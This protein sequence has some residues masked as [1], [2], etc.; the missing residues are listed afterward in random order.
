MLNI[1]LD[2]ELGATFVYIW[3]RPLLKMNLHLDPPLYGTVRMCQDLPVYVCLVTSLKAVIHPASPHSTIFRL[4]SHTLLYNTEREVNY[5]D[6]GNW[7]N[8]IHLIMYCL[9]LCKK[10]YY[11]FFFIFINIVVLTNV[12]ITTVMNY[13]FIPYISIKCWIAGWPKVL[14]FNV[15][16]LSVLKCLKL[17]VLKE[18]LVKQRHQS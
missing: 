16:T 6:D 7:E 10:K 3:N 2:G 9:V 4:W 17:R 13:K 14:L 15:Q 11:Q 12:V 8:N 18:V 5:C 1:V